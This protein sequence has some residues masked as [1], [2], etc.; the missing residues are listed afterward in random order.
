MRTVLVAL[1]HPDDEVGCAGTIAAHRAAG[2][3]VVLL[4]LTR[5]E[6]T[7]I[8][9]HHEPEAVAER[10][11][12]QGREA[13]AILGAEPRFLA[14]PDTRVEHGP[15]AGREVAQ[16]I[17]EVRPDAVVTWGEA[18]SRGMRHPD[19]QATGLI[20]RD[21]ITYARLGRV[22]E[23]PHRDPA[24]VFTLR[25]E[26]STMPVAAVD[27]APHLDIVLALAAF[28]RQRVGWPDEAWLIQRLRRAG[29]AHGLDAAE[30]FD[31]WETPPGPGPRLL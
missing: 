27:V 20:V 10:R 31:A 19:H 29:S 22:V 23:R 21:A 5:G 4:W 18:W 12:E 26:H 17:A 7:E 6:M 30:L 24:P 16:V 15:A 1:A 2:D 13:A 3:R 14:F 28:Y 8:Y 9:G 11:M 25:G